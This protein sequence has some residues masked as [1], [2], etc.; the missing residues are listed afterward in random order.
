MAVE[1]KGTVSE[2]QRSFREIATPLENIASGNF[3]NGLGLKPTIKV[4]VRLLG[5]RNLDHA[6]ELAIMGEDKIWLG[7]TEKK[8]GGPSVIK[9]QS[10]PYY[11]PKNSAYS[12][13][14][15]QNSFTTLNP[16]LTLN[17]VPQNRQ[18]ALTPYN[19]KTT[20]PSPTQGG[21]R[22]LSE[23]EIQYRRENGLCFSVVNGKWAVGQN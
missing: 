15:Y 9:Q 7:H 2:Y 21:V 11:Q 19:P 16:T 12:S 10:I 17:H 3:L 4:E 8:K 22:R 20:T 13:N 5:S 23:K 6:I 18:L 1:Q 14:T